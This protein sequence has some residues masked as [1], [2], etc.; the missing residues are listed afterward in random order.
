MGE[1][2]INWWDFTAK[3]PRKKG[4]WKKESFRQIV[5]SSAKSPDSR[6]LIL[7]DNKG[8]LFGLSLMGGAGL[9]FSY[10]KKI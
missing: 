2:T 5:S 7:G 8:N 1:K 9:I 3:N 10:S 4:V 6:Y